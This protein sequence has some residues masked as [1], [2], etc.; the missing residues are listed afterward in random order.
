MKSW[1][2]KWNFNYRTQLLDKCDCKQI[3][4]LLCAAITYVT[5]IIVT[6]PCRVVLAHSFSLTRGFTEQEKED[7]NSSQQQVILL[8]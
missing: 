8:S 2:N 6:L 5:D 7:Y 1:A 3:L 4:D